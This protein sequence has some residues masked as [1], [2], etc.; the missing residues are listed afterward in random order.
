MSSDPTAP[1]DGDL[2]MIAFLRRWYVYGGGRAEDILVEFGIA[3]VDYFGRV[4][5][6]LETGSPVTDRTV[7][8]G[9]LAV[10]RKRLW[11]GQ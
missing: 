7:S 10:C 1:S 2:A 3:P 4:R 8:D 5:T 11:L 6:L 9:M